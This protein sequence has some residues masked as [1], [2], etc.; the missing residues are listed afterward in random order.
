[1]TGIDLYFKDYE[2]WDCKIMME[3]DNISMHRGTE[4][5]LATPVNV[6]VTSVK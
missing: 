1:M 6:T 2:T 5:F 3:L 4:D